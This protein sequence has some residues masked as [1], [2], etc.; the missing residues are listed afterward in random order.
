[1]E[2]SIGKEKTD[3]LAV[4]I[5]PFRPLMLTEHAL[6]IEDETYHKSWQFNIE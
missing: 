4:M 2:K 6:E 3:E 1:V 5:D